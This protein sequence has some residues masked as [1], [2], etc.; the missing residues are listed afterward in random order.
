LGSLAVAKIVHHYFRPGLSKRQSGLPAKPL[1]AAGNKGY[2]SFKAFS[3]DKY[4]PFPEL[5]RL[6]F[7]T[8]TLSGQALQFGQYT[9]R[10]RPVQ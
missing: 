9:R 1:S 2:F 7:P 6:K 3:H 10:V 4:I 5:F 8:K